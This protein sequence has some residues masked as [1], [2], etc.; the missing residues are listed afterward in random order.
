MNQIPEN[1]TQTNEDTAPLSS[2]VSS[3]AS[4]KSNRSSAYN[5]LQQALAERLP[6]IRRF[7]YSLT[8]SMADADDLVQNTIERVLTRNRPEDV[9]LTKWLFRVCRNLWI[10]EYRSQKVRQQATQQ[11]ELQQIQSVDGEKDIHN[12]LTVEQII[13][14]MDQLPD[15]QRSIL[16][17]IALQGMSY[18]EAADALA[19]PKGTVMSRLSR[20]RQSIADWL[21]H[22]N[23]GVLA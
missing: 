10:D 20:A 23:E 22:N 14:Q 3:S 17:L 7:A 16:A 8:G 11:P 18:Q 1:T 13:K 9:D 19:I 6:M 5:E 15:D 21:K 12:Q 4:N 2:G